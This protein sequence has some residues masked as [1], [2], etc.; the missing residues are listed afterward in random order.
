MTFI[1][2]KKLGGKISKIHNK[3]LHK[4]KNL[5]E[6]HNLK[7]LSKNYMTFHMR[8][9]GKP[10]LLVSN[11]HY[12]DYTKKGKPLENGILEFGNLSK[13]PRRRINNFFI[14]IEVIVFKPIYKFEIII[15]KLII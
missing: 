13:Y 4:I 10:L 6:L 14:D 1:G 9:D 3:M 7:G 11:T 12:T 15:V 8:V 5:E 2:G